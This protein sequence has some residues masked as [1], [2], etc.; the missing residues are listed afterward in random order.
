MSA[1]GSANRARAPDRLFFAILPDD[2]ARARIATWYHEFRLAHGIKGKAID[3]ARYHITLH[4]IGDF[5]GVPE[6]LVS[7][8][9]VVA[10]RFKANGGVDVTLDRARSFS[11]PGS[12][13]GSP[14]VLT[15]SEAETP[16]HALHRRW[17]EAMHDAD[18]PVVSDHAFNP[19]LTLAYDRSVHDEQAISPVRW[20]AREIVLMHSIVGQGKYLPL[21][22]VSLDRDLS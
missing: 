4:F 8:A 22:R 13:R 21:A 16:I 18:V 12:R 20:F 3:P 14:F 11:R 9:L 5:E 6:H 1:I 7:R 10:E 2:G 19:H 17:V 15:C